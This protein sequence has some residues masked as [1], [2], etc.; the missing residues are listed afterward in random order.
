M[1]QDRNALFTSPHVLCAL[2]DRGVVSTEYA[3]AAL[4][5][6]CNLKHWDE[7]YAD[8]LRREYRS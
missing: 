5:Y 4:T 3:S 6:L 8:A 2:A 7:A 1:I